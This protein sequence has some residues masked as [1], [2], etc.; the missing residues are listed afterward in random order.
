LLREQPCQRPYGH[1][2]ELGPRVAAGV[3]SSPRLSV[4]ESTLSLKAPCL[5]RDFSGGIDSVA[6]TAL[7][8]LAVA[9]E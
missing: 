6:P 7:A 4:L 8:A 5:S 3:A 1:R 9:V 2:I